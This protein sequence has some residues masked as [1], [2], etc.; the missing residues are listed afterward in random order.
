MTDI[1]GETTLVDFTAA[2]IARAVRAGELTPVQA[3]EVAA[4]RIGEREP[5]VHAFANLRLEAAHAEARLVAQRPDLGSLALAGVPVAVKDNI[6]VQGEPMRAGSIATSA[7]PAVADHPVVARLRAAG[8]VIVGQTTMNELGAWATTDSPGQV[9]RNPWN[10]QRTCGGSSGGSGAAVAGGLVP[11]AH[12]ND[13][14]GSVRIP[15][16]TCGLVGIKP[17][18]GVVPADVGA[19]SWGGIVE[20]GVLATTVE[21]AALMLSVLADDPAL[22]RVVPPGG[23]LKL[24][25]SVGTQSPVLRLDR[26]CRAAARRAGSVLVAAG[27]LV[28]TVRLPRLPATAEFFRWTAVAARDV[29]A[30]GYDRDLLQPRNRRHIAVGRAV[31]RLHLDR[32]GAVDRLA[33]R[34]RDFFA[35]YHAVL[36]PAFALQPPVAKEWSAQPWLSNLVSSGRFAPFA[37]MWNLLGWPA[38]AVPIGMHPASKTPLAVQIAGPPGS[39]ALLLGLAAQIE[40]RQ[41]WP[42]TA[43]M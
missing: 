14:L 17:G 29:A 13:G 15:A 31:D 1:Q 23:T 36:T 12:G 39:E 22:A 21:D 34:L 32:P 16:A 19:D 41:P 4:T 20:N 10:R 7:A 43:P 24:A 6:A 38:I 28:E 25:L 5:S 40:K 30:G 9:T 11:I 8:A 42:R 37:A 27:H 18:R 33:A 26:H 3:L 35:D 2:G